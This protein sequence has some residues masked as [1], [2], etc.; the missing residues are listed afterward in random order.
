MYTLHANLYAQIVIKSVRRGSAWQISNE[1]G[2]IIIPSSVG[3]EKR[4]DKLLAPI[5]AVVLADGINTDSTLNYLSS[6]ADIVSGKL[7]WLYR[8]EDSVMIR[9]DY[10]LSRRAVK[11]GSEVLKGGEAGMGYY[12]TVIK[13]FRKAK[14]ILIEEDSNSDIRYF[15]SITNG[16]FPNEARYRGWNSTGVE[17]GYENPGQPYRSED[18]RGYPM[19][20]TVNLTQKLI[21]RFAKLYFWDPAGGEG[22]SGRYWMFY[23]RGASKM[24]NLLGIYQGRPSRLIGAKFVGIEVYE[25]K[26]INKQTELSVFIERLGADNSWFSR[27][28]FEWRIFISQKS[29]L[30]PADQI[31]PINTELNKF[32]SIGDRIKNYLNNDAVFSEA[33]NTAS[34]YQSRAY[35]KQIIR[36]IK[37]DDNYY[38]RAC[39]VDPYYTDVFYAWRNVDSANSLINRIID[40][41]ENFEQNYRNG[42]GT[43]RAEYR[44]WKGAIF[45]KQIA[46][47]VS[48]LFGDESLII[49]PEKRRKLESLVRAMARIVWDND[50]VPCQDS[51]GV[52]YGPANMYYQYRNNARAFFALI[53]KDDPEFRN[54]AA[55]VK[56]QVM[57]DLHSVIY[58]NGSTIAVPMYTQPAVDPIL[59]TA[60]Q[61]RQAGLADIFSED[62]RISKFIEFYKSLLTPKSVKYG[63]N[64]K[65]ISFGDGSEQGAATFALLA[66][67]V[68]DT[69][70]KNELYSLYLNGPA[71]MTLAG[72]IMIAVNLPTMIFR[73]VRISSQHYPGYVSHF[74]SGLNTPFESAV[75]LINGDSVYDHRNDDA[76]EVSIYALGCPL[77]VSRNC[78][79]SPSATDARIRSVV[80]PHEAFR[81]WNG[82][83][84]SIN[85]RSLT[86]RTW[87]LSRP[88]SYSSLSNFGSAKSLM[89]SDSNTWVRQINLIW[90][91]KSLPLTIFYD[92]TRGVGNS[93]W[94]MPFTSEG[95][96]SINGKPTQLSRRVFNNGDRNELPSSS[97]AAKLEPG[98]NSIRFTGQ[99]W[100]RDLHPTSGI[101][102]NVFLNAS[103]GDELSLLEWENF[104]QNDAEMKEFESLY[105]R[106]YSELFQ[107]L[108]W[109]SSKPFS[110]VIV[111][112][113]KG[114]RG[115]GV[116]AEMKRDGT[117][118]ITS[119][120]Y[121]YTITQNFVYAVAAERKRE[122]VAFF[123]QDKVQF[124]QITNI[125]GPAEIE[126]VDNQVS[127]TVT[128]NCSSRSIIL[129]G[130]WKFI[131]IL[132]YLEVVVSNESTIIKFKKSAEIVKDLRFSLE[133]L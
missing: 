69:A 8:S 34:I 9:I 73:A 100:A 50:N 110:A 32:S 94:S 66:S 21:P 10:T 25:Q 105:K 114:G 101:D 98:V 87:K 109:K 45:F 61:L 75:W 18:A 2:G 47:K 91:E 52:N 33:F 7:F 13:L 57:D 70:L 128:D 39:A 16:L 24:S 4:N 97:Y 31:Q 15:F 108:R 22:N 71:R 20:A 40:I 48:C 17:L 85:E 120:G 132:P 115:A 106:K 54:R 43:F 11:S 131:D 12:R 96:V 72:S 3:L 116:K 74:R 38:R 80:V 127:I 95:M 78:V 44:Y 41:A 42:E 55:A 81:N 76:G 84:Q 99:K 46:I 92:S 104:S 89:E 111:P 28:R 65:L 26:E 64:R 129:P 118:Y 29:D 93:I 117:A 51:S 19:D 126:L 35:I 77:T 133:K 14:S 86:N 121:K 103:D 59:F 56:G 62:P 53:L 112:Y 90:L 27:K 60:L 37:V 113:T 36:S 123:T 130:K 58:S 63:G 83:D 6:D 23:N 79:Y 30:L 102:W 49:A 107:I 67:G 68:R 88:L 119:S 1:F 125:G 124:A 122:F 82:I 5:Q